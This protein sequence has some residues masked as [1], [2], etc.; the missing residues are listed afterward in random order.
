MKKLVIIK[1]RP[2]ILTLLVFME[3]ITSYPAALTFNNGESVNI[4]AVPSSGYEFIV[5]EGSLSGSDN[6][7]TITM[8]CPKKI[9]ANFYQPLYTL[10]I[11][12]NGSGVTTP[13][14]GKYSYYKG[15]EVSIEATPDDGWQFNGWAGD[16]VETEST[17]TVLTMDSNKTVVADFSQIM[18]TLTIEVNG[19]GSTTPAVG[20]YSYPKG[21]NVNITATPDDGWQFHG[22][23]GDTIEMESTITSLPIDSDIIVIANFS[24]NEANPSAV[25]PIWWLIGCIT[26]GVIIIGIVIRFVRKRRVA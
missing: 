9:T 24:V 20:K 3:V 8:S 2:V 22:W 4:K 19:S 11:E 18:H 15:T 21:T 6:P 16:T 12:S 23:T 26:A 5:W 1:F 25:K 13:S 7:A 10:T 17:T 14:V